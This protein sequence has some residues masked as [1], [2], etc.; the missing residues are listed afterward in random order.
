MKLILKKGA[1]VSVWSNA[2]LLDTIICEKDIQFDETEL[3]ICHRRAFST[4]YHEYQT[5]F[6]LFYSNQVEIIEWIINDDNEIVI[7]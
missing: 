3:K 1:K 5:P 4:R 6:P 7:P 2:K